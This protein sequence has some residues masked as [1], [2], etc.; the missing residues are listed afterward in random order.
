MSRGQEKIDS[1]D[2]RSNHFLDFSRSCHY[3]QNHMQPSPHPLP[4]KL[5]LPPVK[6]HCEAWELLRIK[7]GKG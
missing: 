7:Q 3:K 5:H 4:I 6:A 1:I 2:W